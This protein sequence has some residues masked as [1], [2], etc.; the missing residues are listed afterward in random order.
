MIDINGEDFKRLANHASTKSL[1]H[2]LTSASQDYFAMETYLKLS[3]THANNPII[4]QLAPIAKMH[5][6]QRSTP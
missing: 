4:R 5:K 6:K 1:W 2:L 3:R